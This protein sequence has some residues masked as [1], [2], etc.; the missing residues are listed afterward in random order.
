MQ[1]PKKRRRRE[2]GD[3][4][5][6]LIRQELRIVQHQSGCAT[7]TLNLVLKHLHPFLKGCEKKKAK[8]MHMVNKVKRESSL[9]RQLHGCVRCHDYVFGPRN[10]A[11]NCAKCGFPR[12]NT[13]GK[14]NEVVFLYCL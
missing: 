2:A 13:N 10:H 14:P 3:D 8:Q 4:V 7:S 12:Y 9:K 6:G 11:T 1:A 5:L